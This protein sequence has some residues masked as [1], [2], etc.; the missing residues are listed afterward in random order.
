MYRIRTKLR[1][2]VEPKA[3]RISLTFDE[4][5]E[6]QKA[7]PYKTRKLIQLN[8]GL[9]PDLSIGHKNDN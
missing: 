5:L 3:D 2:V 9:S 4:I 1:L 7:Y 6:K 8:I